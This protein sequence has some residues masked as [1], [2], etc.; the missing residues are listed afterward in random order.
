V[1]ELKTEEEQIEAFR[2]WWKEY[3]AYV[4]GGVVL[5]GLVLFGIN[6][7]GS[8]RLAAQQEASTLYDQLTDEVVDGD[9]EAAEALASQL[10]EEYSN[11]AYVAQS[12][13]AMARLYM[14]ENRDEDAASTLRSLIEL[15]G[16]D[17][18]KQIA[19]LR[20]A[21]VLLYQGKADEA[22]QVVDQSQTEAF[23]AR[24]AEVR[25]DAHTQLEDFEAA[26][27][28]YQDA[29]A[30]PNASQTIDQGYVRLKLMDLPPP[31]VAAADAAEE[32]SE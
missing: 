15:D 26:R 20:L 7:Q 23:A 25:G 2:A 9:L 3:G 32:A 8:A 29:L 11:T 24:F 31:A 22:L 17:E 19:R 5:G 1:D 4:I 16:V 30:Q 18:L 12:K 14:D 28:A 21:K 13:L 27:A 10:A 6:Y